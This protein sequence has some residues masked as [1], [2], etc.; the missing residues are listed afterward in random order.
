MRRLISIAFGL[1]FLVLSVSCVT[2]PVP[3]PVPPPGTPTCDTACARL[4]AL[5]CPA[6]KPTPAG[7]PCQAVC[8]NLE[9]SGIITYGVECV[10]KAESC[11]EADACGGATK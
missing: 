3:P 6:A 7:D 11:A 5:G 9:D 1:A 10:T 4:E 8:A 2:T